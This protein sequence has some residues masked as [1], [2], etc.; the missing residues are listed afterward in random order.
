VSLDAPESDI[1]ADLDTIT[2]RPVGSPCRIAYMR[3]DRPD[4]L[5]LWDRVVEA[6]RARDPRADKAS[7]TD[8]ANWFTKHG[9][10]LEPQLVQRHTGVTNRPCTWCRHGLSA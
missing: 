1:L 10:D 4:L 9:F 7:A 3:R 5:P 6:K 2:K 8:I